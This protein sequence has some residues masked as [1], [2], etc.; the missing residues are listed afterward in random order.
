MPEDTLALIGRAHQGDKEARE[1]LFHENTGLIYCTAFWDVV[2][3][4][5]I[6]FRSEVSAF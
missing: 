3:I 2:W 6:S 1:R 4:W 5:K